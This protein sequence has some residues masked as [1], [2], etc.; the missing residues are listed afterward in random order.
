LI[1]YACRVVI[2]NL[3]AQNH[4]MTEIDFDDMLYLPLVLSLPIPKY[5][6][7]LTD[8]S[9]DFNLCQIL[10]LEKLIGE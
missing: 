5:D 10:I 3:P 9:Q 4:K 1:H 8:E 7:V 2:E 6:L